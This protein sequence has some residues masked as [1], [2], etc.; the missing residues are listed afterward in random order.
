MKKILFS[1]LLLFPL[2][3]CDENDPKADGCPNGSCEYEILENSSISLS[4]ILNEGLIVNIESGNKRVFRR[5]FIY[6]DAKDIIDDELT[7]ILLFETDPGV[8]EFSWEGEELT[9]H[10]VLFG[11]FCYCA[12][13]GYTP[14]S[15]GT[16][17]GK[18]IAPGIWRIKA[19]LNIGDA[20]SPDTFD[21]A[22]D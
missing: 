13:F 14:V 6:P 3:S 1:V 18:M 16:L 8:S 17:E 10:K 21:V 5:T 2:L 19:Q 11:R 15:E 4:N 20:V 7:E 22:F 12:Y 9:E